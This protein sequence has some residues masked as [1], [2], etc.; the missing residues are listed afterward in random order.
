MSPWQSC[1]FLE[2]F[3]YSTL[4]NNIIEYNALAGL[5]IVQQLGIRYLEAYFD[6]KLIINQVTSGYEVMHID[7]LLKYQ[8]VINMAEAFYA[9]CAASWKYV[10][11]Y[12]GFTC[13][14][15]GLPVK[16][17]KWIT[18]GSRMLLCRKIVLEVNEVHTSRMNYE[19]RD[20][21]FIFANLSLY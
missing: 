5:E 17:C 2:V 11:Q 18:M 19:H 16:S 8:V 14:H 7:L 4:S 12:F 13:S 6:S 15:I 10:C 1:T 3:V 20:W 9:L 21:R